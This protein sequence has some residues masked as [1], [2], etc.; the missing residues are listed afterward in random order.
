[1]KMLFASALGAL[2]FAGVAHAESDNG[3][4]TA[5]PPV[6]IGYEALASELLEVTIGRM[7]LGAWRERRFGSGVVLFHK[8]WLLG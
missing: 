1:M 4:E 2:A 8:F 7:R 6:A 5:Y 3:V